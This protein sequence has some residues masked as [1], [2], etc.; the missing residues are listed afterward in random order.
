[1]KRYYQWLCMCRKNIIILEI[2]YGIKYRVANFYRTWLWNVRGCDP[3]EDVPILCYTCHLIFIL[4]YLALY[5]FHPSCNAPTWVIP[6]TIRIWFSVAS[7]LCA[8][9][10][11]VAYK[12]WRATSSDMHHQVSC[13]T[14]F[15]C[16]PMIAWQLMCIY[17]WL[18]GP[19]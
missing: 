9:L 4:G 14:L 16:H 8:M 17:S 13:D 19:C 1:M 5:L 18:C 3:P 15:Y 10:I 11:G 6:T 12:I 7:K 2:I